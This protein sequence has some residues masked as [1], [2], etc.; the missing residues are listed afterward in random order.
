[1]NNQGH[2]EEDSVHEADVERPMIP[3]T[4]PPPEPQHVSLEFSLSLAV[5]IAL[6]FIS[7]RCAFAG[8]NLFFASIVHIRILQ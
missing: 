7:D 5:A 8:T 2:H 6:Y 1:M 4:L 3:A